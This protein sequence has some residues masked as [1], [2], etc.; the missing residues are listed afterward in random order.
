M[1]IAGTGTPAVPGHVGMIA[2]SVPA[3]GGRAAGVY[4]VQAPR[5]G[6]PVQLTPVTAWAGQVVAVRHLA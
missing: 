3:G 1:F 6:R 4:L 5:A 2:G